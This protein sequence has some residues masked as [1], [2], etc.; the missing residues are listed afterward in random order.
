MPRPIPQMVPLF[1]ELGDKTL[2]QYLPED[3]ALFAEFREMVDFGLIR[4]AEKKDGQWVVNA[5]F[6]KALLAGFRLGQI[7]ESEGYA[8]FNF[9]DKQTLP[10]RQFALTSNVRLVPGG[11]AVRDGAFVGQ[12][13]VIMPPS[14]INVGAYV[15]EDTMIDSH[16][17]VGSCAQIGRRVHLSAGVQIGGVLEPV[18]SL[19]VIVEDD[20]MV[21]GNC[22]LYE[23]AIIGER[24]VIGSG[25]ILNS[26]T[27]VYDLVHG[28]IYQRR[29]EQP[30]MIPPGAVVVPG[31]RPAHG[32]FAREHGLHLA[33]PVIVKYRDEKTDAKSALE[34]ALR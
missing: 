33:T 15:A 26:S 2:D 24:A 16:V 14:Y 18:G 21:G 10:T 7:W 31:S 30:L 11:S 28:K 29:D 19:P 17:L 25:V 32:D 5:W 4:C 23:G 8:R 1:T 12:G 3:R 27:K 22:G 6:K 20:V 9:F 34:Q 13:V